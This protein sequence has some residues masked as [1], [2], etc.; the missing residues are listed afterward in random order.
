MSGSNGQACPECA[1]PR[2]PDG[3]PSC[4]CT[5]EASDALRDARTAEVAAAE[6]F[7]PLRIRPYVELAITTPEPDAPTAPGQFPEATTT[8]ATRHSLGAPPKGPVASASPPGEPPRRRRRVVL[9]SAAGAVVAAVA[10]AGLASGM[11]SYEP[12]QRDGAMPEDIRASVPEESSG[13]TSG[14]TSSLATTPSAAPPQSNAVPVPST[15]ASP[16][17][18]PSSASPNPSASDTPGGTPTT[19]G[20]TGALPTTSDSG[21]PQILRRGDSGPEVTELELRLRQVNMYHGPAGGEYGSRV[22]RAVHDYQFARG[23]TQDEPGVYGVAT[24]AKLESETT[25]P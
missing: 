25:Q 1:A 13:G 3:T 2:R 18:S 10:A 15:S 21:G 6:D 19:A 16:S 14:G 20:A 12:P 7:D 23:I 4:G 11:F 9:L 22:E 24:R 8:Q 5:R 17:R